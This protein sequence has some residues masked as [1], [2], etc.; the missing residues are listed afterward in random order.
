MRAFPYILILVGCAFAIQ[1]ILQIFRH[2]R[3]VDYLKAETHFGPVE[4]TLIA[5]RHS[6]KSFLWE[7]VLMILFG[8]FAYAIGLLGAMHS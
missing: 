3:A 1:G 7:G 6:R 4:D 5:L 8:L 2:F